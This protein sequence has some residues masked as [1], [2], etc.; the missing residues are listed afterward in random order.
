MVDI[1]CHILPGLDDGAADMEESLDM[2]R[3][4]L[5]CGITDIVATPHFRGD[6]SPE[7]QLQRIWAGYQYFCRFLEKKNLPLRVHPGAEILCT[8]Q[9]GELARQRALPT[10]G[11]SDYVLTEFFFDTPFE[12]M[13]RMLDDIARWGYRPVIAHP[14]R[15]DAI[16]DD[17]RGIALWV[18][19][20][21]VIQL[22]KGSILGAF[23]YRVQKTAEWILNGGL[24]HLVASDAHGA[25]RRTPDMA[26]LLARLRSGY[27][28][29]YVRAL[30][31]YN[32]DRLL[33]GLDMLS[34][35]LL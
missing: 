4:A 12:L 26:P 21:Y 32:P 13:D 31:Q 14:E 8:P 29:S 10:L 24:A 23:G 6:R 11:D 34:E 35:S 18:R 1:H 17:P 33:R 30:T 28:E 22:N 16:V 27:P 15:Y 3:S 5:S 2:A 9:V 7:E 19:K 25:E 20:R